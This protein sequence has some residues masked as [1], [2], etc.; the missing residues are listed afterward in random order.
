MVRMMVPRVNGQAAIYANPAFTPLTCTTILVGQ[1]S[2][3]TTEL[4][5]VCHDSR[6]YCP[7]AQAKSAVPAGPVSLRLKCLSYRRISFC[8]QHWTG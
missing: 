8:L 2:G 5:G 6:F 4:A 1:Q 3:E 7:V